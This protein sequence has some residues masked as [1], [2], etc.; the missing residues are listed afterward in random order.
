M[1]RCIAEY[2]EMMEDLAV[3]NLVGRTEAHV[4]EFKLKSLPRTVSI[5]HSSENLLPIAE[6]VKLEQ[7][8]TSTAT[9]K[10][11]LLSIAMKRTSEWTFSN[12]IPRDVTVN[13]GGT[14][15]SLHKFP[16]ISKG[17]YLRKLVLESEDSDLSVIEIP[18]ISGGP[19]AFEFAAKILLWNKLRNKFRKHYHA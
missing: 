11:E 15:F 19:E 16:S 9:N 3:G 13:A 14:S 10:E 5:L 2:L 8:T 12:E 6:E 18:D 17:G 4:N 7:T 1:L